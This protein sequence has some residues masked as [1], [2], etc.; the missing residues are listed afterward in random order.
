MV[1]KTKVTSGQIESLPNGAPLVLHGIDLLCCR[2]NTASPCRFLPLVKTPACGI[3]GH[4]GRWPSACSR[5][6]GA[7]LTPAPS[8]RTGK[9]DMEIPMLGVTNIAAR[10]RSA[11]V[12]SKTSRIS[13][14]W[15][16][17]TAGTADPSGRL[18]AQAQRFGLAGARVMV[19]GGTK[20]I[21]AGIVEELAVSV[22]STPGSARRILQCSDA[23]P[24]RRTGR[25]AAAA[26]TQLRLRSGHGR[27]RFHVRA[28]RGRSLGVPGRV[29]DP[30][31]R[32]VRHGGGLRQGRGPRGAR[33]R[34]VGGVR[35]PPRRPRQ[36]RRHQRPQAD[37]TPPR[38]RLRHRHSACATAT[39]PVP[40]PPH[41]RHRAQS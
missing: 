23:S 4:T 6:C 7:G 27:T 33:A 12:L 19:T 36:Q 18:V 25:A 10:E 30:R 13:R 26:G 5:R 21:G 29:G 28:Q 15:A 38:P 31:A 37:G 1:K 24:T 11:Q 39:A 41:P 16:S 3:N 35:R 9:P 17:S 32:R 34:R 20:G 22:S 40:P 8:T 14:L 2:S